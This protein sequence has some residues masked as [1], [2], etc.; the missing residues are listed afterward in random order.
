VA[1]LAFLIMAIY[2]ASSFKDIKTYESNPEIAKQISVFIDPLQAGFATSSKGEID[3]NQEV[4]LRNVCDDNNYFGS[5]RLSIATMGKNE[6]YSDYGSTITVNDKYIFSNDIIIDNSVY[7]LSKTFSYPYEVSDFIILI[8]SSQEYCLEDVPEDISDNLDLLGID[9]LYFSNCSND[10][11]MVQICTSPQNC[12]IIITGYCTSFECTSKYNFGTVKKGSDT[13]YY[14]NDLIYSAIFS[15]I[16][17][18]NCNTRRLINR[19]SLL[20]EMYLDKIN[21]LNSRG[22][23]NYLAED[24]LIWKNYMSSLSSDDIVNMLDYYQKSI[25]LNNQNSDSGCKLW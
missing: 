9:N 13:Y 15:D 8:P 1:G 4:K 18:Y 19:N 3:F 23:T 6:E 5:N 25:D 14:T 11:N 10:E 16:D 24:L 22:C 17:N 21:L 2:A 7:T 12:D 20:A